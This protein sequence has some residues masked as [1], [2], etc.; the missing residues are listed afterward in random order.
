MYTRRPSSEIDPDPVRAHAIRQ[1]NL[2]RGLQAHALTYVLANLIQV[3][4]WFAYTPEQFFWPLWSILGWGLGLVFHAWAVF[5]G[6]SLDEAR[7]QREIKRLGG[8]PPV[9]PP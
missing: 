4:V 6:S 1:L 5:S 7:I 8:T 9:T 2:K 3:V